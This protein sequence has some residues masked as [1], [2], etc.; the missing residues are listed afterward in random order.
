MPTIRMK[1][2]ELAAEITGKL[3]EFPK[4]TTQIINLANQNAQGTRPKYVGQMTELFREFGGRT[5]EE[6]NEWYLQEKPDAIDNATDRI[7]E[8]IQ[9]LRKAIDL[10]DRQMVRDWVEDLVLAKT[11]VGLS[12]QE[13]VLSRIASLEGKEY[14]IS[15]P[16]EESKGIDGYIGGIAV[17]LKPVTYNTKTA[18]RENIEVGIISYKKRKEGIEFSYDFSN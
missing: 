8:M 5:Y 4:Y 1:N 9:K 15:T 17:S 18:L 6:W 10:V 12:F 2:A 16:A 7:F 3:R 11:F 14:R 13:A